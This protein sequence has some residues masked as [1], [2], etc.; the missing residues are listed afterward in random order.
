MDLKWKDIYKNNIDR[1]FC[2]ITNI[3]QSNIGLESDVKKFLKNRKILLIIL[4]IIVLILLIITFHKD[5]KVLL[6]VISFLIAI[7][8]CFIFF[9]HFKLQCLEDGLFIKFGFQQGK[10]PYERVKNIYLSKF[11][12][13]SFLF[14]SRTY[15]IVI[16]YID[17][18]NK[19]KELSF[20]N[21]FVSKEDMVKFL[22]NFEIKENKNNEYVNYE[23]FKM[24]K[25]I[26][27]ILGFVVL[28]VFVALS[29][30]R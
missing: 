25:Q 23:R 24:V 2:E 7:A 12:D 4:S 20:P 13:Y 17:T 15:N 18:F 19:L 1:R 11:N 22:E 26:L 6:V 29:L 10:F 28:V 16:R 8:G 27:K 5:L 3:K 14:P 30:F 21:Y 9:N